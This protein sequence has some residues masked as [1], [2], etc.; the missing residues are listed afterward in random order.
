M[1]RVVVLVVLAVALLLVVSCVPGPNTLADSP[2]EE[3]NVAGFWQGLWH[4]VIAPITFIISLFS[5]GVHMY[6][7]HNN[8]GW[9]NFG[10]LL[11][12]AIILGSGGGGAA[13]KRSRR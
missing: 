3:G 12:M 9:Y 13:S 2:N 1:K 7:V 8:G 5:E 11:G 6:E 4:G 10:Y